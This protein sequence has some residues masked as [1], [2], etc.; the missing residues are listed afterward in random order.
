MIVVRVG[1]HIT[2]TLTNVLAV[3]SAAQALGEDLP[4]KSPTMGSILA[5]YFWTETLA[6]QSCPLHHYAIPFTLYI[7]LVHSRSNKNRA[8]V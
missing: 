7:A 6:R 4:R 1:H 2:T 8:V 3:Y 5:S